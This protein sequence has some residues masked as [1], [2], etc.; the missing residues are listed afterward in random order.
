MENVV[1]SSFRASPSSLSDSVALGQKAIDES[2]FVPYAL[3]LALAQREGAKMRAQSFQRGDIIFQMI[4]GDETYRMGFQSASLVLDYELSSLSV[5][6]MDQNECSATVESKQ[7][8]MTKKE[9]YSIWERQ[10][11]LYIIRDH[12]TARSVAGAGITSSHTWHERLAMRTRLLNCRGS[13]KLWFG[14][15][16]SS[17]EGG[18]ITARPPN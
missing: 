17:M 7:C 6:T 5:I 14:V 3:R 2:L 4:A 9:N 16:C 13:E 15:Y 8:V 11:F 10:Y 1:N 18:V 12:T